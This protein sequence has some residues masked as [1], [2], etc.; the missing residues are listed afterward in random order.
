MSF[1]TLTW[2]WILAGLGALAGLLFLL[3]RLRIRHR[4]VVVPTTLFWRAAAEEA[5]A[6]TLLERFRH[7]WAYVLILL[8]CA[9][10]WLA[11]SNP[12]PKD[13][14]DSTLHV[15]VLDAS[16]VMTAGSRYDDAVA[17]LRSHVRALPAS[18][19]QVIWSG[20]ETRTLLNPGEHDLLLVKRL[21]GLRPD[22]APIQLD[23]LLRSF[24]QIARP[25][26]PV[27]VTLFGASPLRFAS[28][29]ASG[30]L[31]ITRAALPSDS[32]GPN[33]GI[34]SLGMSDAASGAWSEVDVY[35]EVA[36]TD[37]ATDPG[38]QIELD[39]V[40]LP[41]ERLAALPLSAAKGY[42]IS[43][44]PATG[45]LLSVRLPDRDAIAADNS[46]ELRLPIRP[47]I[48]V[49]LSP[50]LESLR[51]ALLADPAVELASEGSH[52]VIRREGEQFGNGQPAI[53]FVTRKQS[54]AFSFVHPARLDSRVVLHEA[55]MSTGLREVDAN[56][57]AS[58]AQ[59]A[60]EVAVLPGEQWQIR[61]W[62]ELITPEFNFT[63]S[64]A[65]PL[66]LSNSIRWLAQVPGLLP[67]AAAG[68][69]LVRDTPD[70]AARI[71]D[72]AGR[73]VDPLGDAF[74]PARAGPL[75][76]EGQSHPIVVSLLDAATTV[77]NST[78]ASENA[79][80]ATSLLIP[81]PATWLLLLALLLLLVEWHLLQSGRIP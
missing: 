13:Q 6:R 7:P 49:Q 63:D 9:L 37:A 77:A 44:L 76:V 8:I 48:R 28:E 65:F 12:T 33:Q 54:A 45:G 55:V 59:Q 25:D 19:R 81:H 3:Q 15:A 58:T 14:A 4:K 61:L 71:L 62:G 18:Q 38:L 5:P 75:A 52:V 80:A 23:T 35:V 42:L 2:P 30:S 31:R 72:A 10:L 69:P 17:A 39:G 34:V 68:R 74:I 27:S 41:P 66:F 20:G 73:A 32:T 67:Y 70:N 50:S 43:S 57:L 40:P 78:P 53:E 26:R 36:G 22:A 1:T 64:R 24:G 56:E 79:P 29:S 21:N 11:F 47:R 60:I 51:K 46:A 16:A